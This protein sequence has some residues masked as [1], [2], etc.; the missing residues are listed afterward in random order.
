MKV[1]MTAMMIWISSQTGWEVPTLP[2]LSFFTA[3]EMKHYAYGCDMD[4]V[5]VGNE[6]LCSSKEFWYLDEY[7]QQNIPLGLYDHKK[8]EIIVRDGFDIESIH[9]QSILLHELVHHMQFHNGVYE[10]VRCRGELEKLAYKLQDEWLNEKYGL[11]VN[12]VIG[13]NDLFMFMV[14]HCHETI[15]PPDP[16]IN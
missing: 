14:T 1:F 13:I 12:D 2:S 5:P 16:E 10:K 9:D 15:G 11:R 8:Q 6:D 3:Q 4:P 7:E